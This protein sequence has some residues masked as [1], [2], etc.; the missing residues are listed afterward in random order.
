MKNYLIVGLLFLPFLLFNQV[1][2]LQIGQP[3][4][5]V[6]DEILAGPDSYTY[7]KTVNSRLY[8]SGDDGGTWE[9]LMLPPSSNY[10]SY[11]TVGADSNLYL[12]L[13]GVLY[14]MDSESTDWTSI[15]MPDVLFSFSSIVVFSD[16]GIMLVA[17]NGRMYYRDPSTSD[18]EM[19]YSN[20]I[21]QPGVQFVM[22]NDGYYFLYGVIKIWRFSL[23]GDPVV[24]LA[25]PSNGEILD[26]VEV[27]PDGDLWFFANYHLYRS[28]NNGDDWEEVSVEGTGTPNRVGF[29]QDDVVYVYWFR[30]PILHSSSDDG[31]NWE[32]AID[33]STET[34]TGLIPVPLAS[35]AEL[36]YQ[37]DCK[38]TI[39]RTTDGGL[40]HE[41]IFYNIRQSKIIGLSGRATERLYVK[42]CGI[43]FQFTEDNGLDWE[44]IKINNQQA[45]VLSVGPNNEL[46]ASDY[47]NNYYV[48]VDEGQS[49]QEI[50]IP[51]TAEFYL[52]KGY[53]FPNNTIVMGGEFGDIFYSLDGAEGEIQRY[54]PPDYLGEIYYHP[55]D[56]LFTL[57]SEASLGTRMERID[58]NTNSGGLLENLPFDNFLPIQLVITPQGTIYYLGKSSLGTPVTKIFRSDDLG[59]SFYEVFSL[60]TDPFQFN[61]QSYSL[62]LDPIGNIYLFT[63]TEII[64]S[65][66]Q[67]ISW[68]TYLS[69]LPGQGSEGGI[70]IDADNYLYL[71]R[72]AGQ[73]YRSAVPL[74]ALGEVSGTLWNDRNEDCLTQEANE[75]FLSSWLVAATGNTWTFYTSTNNNGAYRLS[76]PEGSFTLGP[77]VNHPLYSACLADASVEVVIDEAIALDFPVEPTLLCPLITANVSVP[78]LRRCFDNIYTVRVCNEGTQVADDTH[79]SIT[80]DEFFVYQT[81]TLDPV[82]VGG[83]TYTFALGDLPSGTCTTFNL[84]V[85]LSCEAELGQEHCV[86]WSTTP[87]NECAPAYLSPVSVECQHNIGSYDPNDKRAFVNGYE[88]IDFLVPDAERLTYHIRFQN[89]GTDTAFTVLIEDKLPSEL[90]VT[91]FHL[92]NSS[93]PCE[94]N[95]VP[96]DAVD[97]HKLNF[98]FRNIL[99]PDST[100]NEPASHG[101]VR[102]SMA[103]KAG[104]T[105]GED[106]NNFADIFFDFNEPIRTNTVALEY[107]YPSS[108]STSP[109]SKPVVYVYPNPTTGRINLTLADDVL[110]PLTVVCYNTQGQALNHHT[111]SEKNTIL[112]LSGWSPGLY[113]LQIMAKEGQLQTVKVVVD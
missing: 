89:T 67:G 57:N 39:I 25:L 104:L 95:I 92:E 72:S 45:Q 102:F 62:M 58:M 53:F 3:R 27:G 63:G 82:E 60:P 84:T 34:D 68:Q 107:N 111:L 9:E 46:L 51:S 41:N 74:V 20:S 40:T 15:E 55:E 22:G 103:P 26:D 69:D 93:H 13:S 80:L 112:D 43:G 8:R 91:T 61:L 106:I 105:L 11:W 110:L 21:F 33:L 88:T 44:R 98:L 54:Y 70:Y 29:G 76:L 18:W 12:F 37:T 59:D 6:I 83:Q 38:S 97:T 49:W 5:A 94:V 65:T 19:K 24:E 73:I 17:T 64:L 108:V 32:L 79:I 71:L 77:V 31:A 96:G 56:Y 10:I 75:P 90:D 2:W 99:L 23:A 7:L 81:S 66:D 16:G 42:S 78:L 113:F 36:F 87:D 28:E 48:S 47:A 30:N 86:S 4:G 50:F 35:G 1:D 14:R 109:R 52:D 100:T 85:N 101:F